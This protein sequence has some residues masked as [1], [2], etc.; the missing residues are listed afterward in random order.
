MPRYTSEGRRDDHSPSIGGLP[1]GLSG[2]GPAFNTRI[3]RYVVSYSAGTRVEG[4]SFEKL[5][6]IISKMLTV[7]RSAVLKSREKYSINANTVSTCVEKNSVYRW[8]SAR[9]GVAISYMVHLTQIWQMR[10]EE[11]AN[12]ANVR[13]SVSTVYHTSVMATGAGI[14]PSVHGWLLLWTE[15]DYERCLTRIQL[16]VPCRI[17]RNIERK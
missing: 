1:M 13:I 14:A 2:G 3:V 17:V 4:S 5:A 16:F 10:N 7:W 11:F 9:V 8:K 15:R 6:H 12:V